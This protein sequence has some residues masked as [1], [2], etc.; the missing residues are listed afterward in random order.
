M[1]VITMT[2]TSALAAIDLYFYYWHTLPVLLSYRLV[3]LSNGVTP[4][5]PALLLLGAGYLAC[6]S[7]SQRLSNYCSHKYGL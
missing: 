6:L 1:L 4:L 5:T 2:A 7:Q 3:N